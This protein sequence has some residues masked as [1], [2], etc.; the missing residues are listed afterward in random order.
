MPLDDVIKN[1]FTKTFN[2]CFIFFTLSL[3]FSFAL[4][5][6]S[7]PLSFLTLRPLSSSRGGFRSQA[8]F[9]IATGARSP[10]LPNAGTEI[11]LRAS[12]IVIIAQIWPPA[13]SSDRRL[14]LE[15]RSD[16]L[17]SRSS[18]PQRVDHHRRSDQRW[19]R[20]TG[21]VREP[22]PRG[23][24]RRRFATELRFQTPTDWIFCFF[25]FLY[26]DYFYWF[27]Y[28]IM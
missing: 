5:L 19:R 4:S 10:R 14:A 12:Q 24:L 26:L 1:L 22:W 11:G 25:N 16:L 13:A 23:G 3:L 27:W 18:P 6:P 28:I 20:Q 2:Y 21:G 15:S 7:L 9:V 17:G 8:V